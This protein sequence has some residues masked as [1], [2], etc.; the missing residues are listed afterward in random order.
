MET[1]CGYIAIHSDRVKKG[2]FHGECYELWTESFDSRAFSPFK[3]KKD[4]LIWS[5]VKYLDY[6]F[7]HSTLSAGQMIKYRRHNDDHS[8]VYVL[9]FLVS[10]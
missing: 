9:T 8:V 3:I 10:A 5:N 6:K 2:L 4:I 1:A 7:Y